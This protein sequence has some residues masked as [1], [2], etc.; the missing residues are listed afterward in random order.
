M[1]VGVLV[2]KLQHQ[3]RAGDPAPLHPLRPHP[4]L[5]DAQPGHEVPQPLLRQPEVHQRPERHIPADAA[6]RIEQ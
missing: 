6:E 5:R 2:R 3:A 1:A 4:D